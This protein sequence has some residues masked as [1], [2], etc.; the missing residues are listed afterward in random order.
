MQ[1]LN[2][3]EDLRFAMEEYRKK[4]R[5]SHHKTGSLVCN[6]CADRHISP[7]KLCILLNRTAEPLRQDVVSPLVSH[8]KLRC[9]KIS[10]NDPEQAYTAISKPAYQD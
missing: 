1:D 8:G 4:A 3:P 5:Q 2:L 10:D 6:L 7:S 9:T